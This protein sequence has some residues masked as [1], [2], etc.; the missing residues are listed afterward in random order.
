MIAVIPG[1][2][3][4]AAGLQKDDRIVS[5][6]GD[7]VREVFDLTQKM[8]EYDPGDTGPVEVMRGEERVRLEVTYDVLRHGGDGGRDLHSSTSDE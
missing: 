2:P 5:A 3:A 6:G 4:E 7:A 1:G 8:T